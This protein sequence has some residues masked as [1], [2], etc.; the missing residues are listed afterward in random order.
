MHIISELAYCLIIVVLAI[1]VVRYETKFLTREY[2]FN[3]RPRGQ[4]PRSTSESI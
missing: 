1:V 4:K 2:P 3:P